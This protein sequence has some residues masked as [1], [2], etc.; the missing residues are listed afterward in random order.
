ML[1]A[2]IKVAWGEELHH[3]TINHCK[4]VSPFMGTDHAIRISP[5]KLSEFK[6]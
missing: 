3:E 1:A 2:A 5:Q 4:M 6:T